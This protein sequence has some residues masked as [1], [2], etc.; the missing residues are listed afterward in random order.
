VLELELE[1]LHR[2]LDSVMVLGLVQ[3]G[4]TL[5]RR[6]GLG[7]LI[8]IRYIILMRGDISGRSLLRISGGGKG[9]P[10][11]VTRLR[12][13]MLLSLGRGLGLVGVGMI[14]SPGF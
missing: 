10:E 13:S 9:G 14:R 1:G 4:R 7:L 11:L 2:V 3:A 6:I 5:I 12:R 8:G